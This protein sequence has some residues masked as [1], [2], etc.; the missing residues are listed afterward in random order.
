MRRFHHTFEFANGSGVSPSAVVFATTPLRVLLADATR[1]FLR[2]GAPLA[3]ARRI[4]RR[5]FA[6]AISLIV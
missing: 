3:V 1:I 5:I 6:V 4:A 2:S